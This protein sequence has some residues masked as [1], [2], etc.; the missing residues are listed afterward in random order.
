MLDFQN[1]QY[2]KLLDNI[3]QLS[4]ET[5]D[6]ATPARKIRAGG[7]NILSTLEYV[8][9]DMKGYF[10]AKKRRG[11]RDVGGRLVCLHMID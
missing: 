10:L 11:R 5:G 1:Q 2:G 6:G 4:I 8:T 9:D 3:Y 7:I